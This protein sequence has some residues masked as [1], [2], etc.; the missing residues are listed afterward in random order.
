MPALAAAL[1]SPAFYIGSLG[2]FT[3]QL[4][5]YRQLARL[6]YDDAAVARVF[7]PIGLDLKG[8]SPAEIA[9]SIMAEITAVRRGGSFPSSTM[10]ASA[11]RA[12]KEL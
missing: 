11:R 7:G 6:G 12:E 8:R 3:T 1:D 10:L 2:R 9:L 5:R 4:S